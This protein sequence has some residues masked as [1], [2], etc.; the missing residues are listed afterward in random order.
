MIPDI[1]SKTSPSVAEKTVFAILA[2][3]AF[4]AMVSDGLQVKGSGG[5]RPPLKIKMRFGKR[6]T[7]D[8]PSFSILLLK[9]ADWLN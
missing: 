4:L 8:D 5:L 9:N 2:F 7:R 3:F 6:S 1:R